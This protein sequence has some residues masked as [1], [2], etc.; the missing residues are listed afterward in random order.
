MFVHCSHCISLLFQYL[1][2]LKSKSAKIIIAD[3]VESVARSV[4][5]EALNLQMT[6]E[7]GY[8][9]FLPKWLDKEWYDTDSFNHRNNETVNCT[10]DQMIRVSTAYSIITIRVFIII[11]FRLFISQPKDI[12]R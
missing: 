7:D 9:W 2:D 4:M 12:C 11:R 1:Q 10:T 3:V 6:A 8:V 5:C